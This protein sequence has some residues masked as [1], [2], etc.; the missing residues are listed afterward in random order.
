LNQT[1]Y[2]TD[3]C[4]GDFYDE[5]VFP[6]FDQCVEP[7]DDHGDDDEFDD[8]DSALTTFEMGSCSAMDVMAAEVMRIDE[9]TEQD[10][11]D[12]ASAGVIL[13]WSATLLATI[14]NYAFMSRA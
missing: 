3:D 11:D 4:T 8:D 2:L 9:P 5:D 13:S 12:A 1:S 7:E 14:A 6:L 10:D